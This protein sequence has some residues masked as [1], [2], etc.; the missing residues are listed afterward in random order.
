M[1]GPPGLVSRRIFQGGGQF[2]LLPF[3]RGD[4]HLEFVQVL[5]F[6]APCFGNRI[7]RFRS[8]TNDSFSLMASGLRLA[9]PAPSISGRAQRSAGHL[10]K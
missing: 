9:A 10:C 8:A 5:F 3:Q 1:I 4:F 7:A 6:L 2:F